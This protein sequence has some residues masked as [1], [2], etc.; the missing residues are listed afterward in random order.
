MQ[1]RMTDTVLKIIIIIIILFVIITATSLFQIKNTARFDMNADCEIGQLCDY[2]GNIPSISLCSTQS[3]F[4]T[5]NDFSASSAVLYEAT[6]G[7]KI[8]S[9][10]DNFH[11]PNASTTKILTALTVLERVDICEEIVIPNEAVGVEGSSIYLKKGEKM[12]VRDLLTGLMLQ[13]GNDAA[14]ALALHVGKTKAGFVAMMNETARKYG[15]VSSNFVTPHGLHD[16]N[17]YTTAIDLALITSA[18][19]KN[20]IFAEIVA[21][22]S[23]VIGF[24]ENKRH[25]INKNKLL[26]M[27]PEAVGVKTGFTK[28]AGRCLVA[29]A[30][31]DDALFIVVV[32]NCGPMFE[33]CRDF[34]RFAIDNYSVSCVIRKNQVLG[35]LKIDGISVP[36]I[37][38]AEFKT[39]EKRGENRDYRVVLTA[40]KNEKNGAVGFFEVISGEKVV[41]RGDLFPV[42]G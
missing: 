33:E 14:E 10:N 31:K 22:R 25:I 35:S 16:P 5:S 21:K 7:T 13:S 12:T 34:L 8:L 17:H 9:K 18:A 29:A 19:M 2:K 1:K 42:F 32:L 3:A 40:E 27:L 4:L 38:H 24:G 23:A 30:K 11:L 28:K 6:T 15:A 36:V 26:N 39:L 20:E 41:F 37:S